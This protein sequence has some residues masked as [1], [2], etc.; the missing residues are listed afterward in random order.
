MF[1]FFINCSNSFIT[2]H[3]SLQLPVQHHPLSSLFLITD[4]LNPRIRYQFS[5]CYFQYFCKH[6]TWHFIFYYFFT[7]N[8]KKKSKSWF[9]IKISLPSFTTKKSCLFQTFLN[10][11]YKLLPSDLVTT[12]VQNRFLDSLPSLF[13]C[14]SLNNIVQSA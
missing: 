13:S 14:W 4:E 9:A 1:A 12:H 3:H 7:K 5:I 11:H 8:E 2:K 6:N 10:Y